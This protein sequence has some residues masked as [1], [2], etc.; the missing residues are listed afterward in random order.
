MS[1]LRTIATVFLGAAFCGAPAHAALIKLFANLTHDQEAVQGPFLTSTGGTRPESF[2]TATFILDTSVPFMTMSAT[3]FNIDVNGLQT[4]NDTNDNLTA[5]HI[6][7]PT[8]STTT[9]TFPVRWGFFG[10][11]D[12]DNN[13]DNLVVTPFATGVGGTFTST[14]DA[15][16]GNAGTTLAAE[17][18]D[19]LSGLAYLNFHTVQY[20]G[21]E[22]RGNLLAIP[23]P[24]S[25]ALIGLGLA[26]F[27]ALRRRRA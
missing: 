24:G 17:L 12:N 11:P 5:A 3:I 16:E 7:A 9:P 26:G 1:L 23:E 15:P 2:G 6:H 18:D 4:P 19:I 27:A 20:G 13:P 8:T 10:A 21:G 14:W 25:F 22:I